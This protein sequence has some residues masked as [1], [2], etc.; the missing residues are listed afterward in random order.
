MPVLPADGSSTS[1]RALEEIERLARRAAAA[2][3]SDRARLA[4]RIAARLRRIPGDVPPEPAARWLLEAL[5]R[6]TW[7]GFADA[8]G[9]TCR[10]AAV[11]ALLALGYPWAL[12]VT[13]EDLEHYRAQSRRAGGS[14][15]ALGRALRRILRAFT[16]RPRIDLS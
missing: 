3:E 9:R 11:E 13:P 16:G 12:H 7:V 14:R 10:A 5:E 4:R 8:R 15:A 2:P 6:S 1:Q